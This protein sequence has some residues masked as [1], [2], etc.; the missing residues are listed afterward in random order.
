VAL[1]GA[2]LQSVS[3][4][5]SVDARTLA[6][7]ALAAVLNRIGEQPQLL[8]TRY[9]ATVAA[10]AGEVAKLAAAG[11]LTR[12]QAT[13]LI[14]T[15]VAAVLRNPELFSRFEGRVATA[16]VNGVLRGAKDSQLA[17]FGG[18]LLVDTLGEVL[19][20]VAVRGR[21]LV[22]S[23]TE[24]ALVSKVADTISAGLARSEQELGRRLDTIALPLVL[25][26]LVAAVARGEIATIAA[27]DPKFQD[28]FAA[29]AEAALASRIA[30]G[31][32]A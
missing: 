8:A 27:A 20:V 7:S 21:N 24:E 23:T 6:N 28:V 10:L 19:R 16:V 2:V 26:G 12:A 9:P 4:A 13:D 22:D 1:I 32:R 31:V 15:A 5:G 30:G 14:D 18:T 25:A 11:T 29:L 17:L 3:A